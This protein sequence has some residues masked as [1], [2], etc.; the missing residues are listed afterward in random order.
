D[1]LSIDS[2]GSGDDV[3][4]GGY[5]DANRNRLK[6]RR[7]EAFS[8][9]PVG[10]QAYFNSQAGVGTLAVIPGGISTA[11]SVAAGGKGGAAGMKPTVVR[12]RGWHTRNRYT[13]VAK[14]SR[15]IE[16]K[17]ARKR[18][19]ESGGSAAVV[20]NYDDDD[21]DSDSDGEEG[22][23]HGR[24][25]WETAGAGAG[26]YGGEGADAYAKLEELL[27]AAQEPVRDIVDAASSK[28]EKRFAKW[29]SQMDW[30][31]SLMFYGVGSKRELLMK[32][33]DYVD[34]QNAGGAAVV[35]YD[36]FNANASVRDLLDGLCRELLADEDPEYSRGSLLHYAQGFIRAFELQ[37]LPSYSSSVYGRSG[38]GGGG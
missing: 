6:K 2:G 27:K 36:G 19:R 29:K 26:I 13:R 21:D 35:G 32:F 11:S 15:L 16:E 4:G 25:R 28:A 23:D 20:N 22:G 30:G 31:W 1:D 8:A 37:R 18:A 5:G 38:G 12:K 17:A 24:G 14:E 7:T 3:G 9:V 34:E 10:A 33:E